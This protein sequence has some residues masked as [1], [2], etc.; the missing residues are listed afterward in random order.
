ML[1][2]SRWYLRE[3][4]VT[5]NTELAKP[6][7]QSHQKNIYHNDRDTECLLPSLELEEHFDHTP[8]EY[9]H[10]CR[11]VLEARR[12]RH[13]KRQSDPSSSKLALSQNTHSANT[14]MATRKSRRISMLIA[15]LSHT[16]TPKDYY[17][18]EL[19]TM[20]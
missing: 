17:V 19:L 20:Q 15:A 18:V 11:R 10:C 4:D 3:V 7:E 12:K 8:H 2:Y 1:D 6:L 13:S 9:H 16:A 5:Y 14:R